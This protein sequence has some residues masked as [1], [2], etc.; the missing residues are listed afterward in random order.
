M[1]TRLTLPQQR[2]LL[3]ALPA[4]RVNAC[5][6]HC[7]ACQ[8]RGEGLKSILKSIGR[9]LGPVAKEIGPTVLKQFVLPMVK[10]K[11][12]MGLT[13]PGGAL[14]LAGQRGTGRARKAPARRKRAPARRAPARRGRPRGRGLG[15]V[16]I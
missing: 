2:A 1:P 10:K 5:K 6:R 9:V 3:R 11:L 15:S 12:G 7:Q 14:R 8:M 16:R 4:S 13:P